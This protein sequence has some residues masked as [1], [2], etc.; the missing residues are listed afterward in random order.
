MRF[1]KG[2]LIVAVAWGTHAAH[3]VEMR[4]DTHQQY[5]R[6][7]WKYVAD[8]EPWTNWTPGLVGLQPAH[9]PRMTGRSRAYVNPQGWTDPWAHGS[10]IVARH[11]ATEAKTGKPVALSVWYR[12]KKD[13]DPAENDW[14]WAHWLADG[15]LLATSADRSSGFRRGFV[16]IARGEKLWVFAQSS[17]AIAE[18]LK[19]GA[20]DK[21]AK[22][23]VAGPDGK[24][25]VAPDDTTIDAYLS[26]DMKKS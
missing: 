25:L 20:L 19:N 11:F 24:T 2:L 4:P 26:A 21:S 7:L 6:T 15:T 3:A 22:R 23:A 12:V 16:T 1:H 14:Y 8:A 13:Y 5:S 9:G 17:P 18:F 10:L